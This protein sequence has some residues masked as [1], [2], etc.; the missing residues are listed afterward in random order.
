MKYLHIC[1]PL[2]VDITH[3]R[4][5]KAP[6]ALIHWTAALLLLQR[7]KKAR[8]SVSAQ[9][10][11]P[12]L[13]LSFFLL[14]SV[15]Y[16]FAFCSFNPSIHSISLCWTSDSLHFVSQSFSL[17]AAIVLTHSFLSVFPPQSQLSFEYL[18][19]STPSN[20]SNFPSASHPNFL[21]LCAPVPSSPTIIYLC[22][23][24]FHVQTFS[25]SLPKAR[26]SSCFIPWW[27]QE[28]TSKGV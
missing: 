14:C 16:L 3:N 19:S 2:A 5:S 18:S 22:Q 9:R 15:F 4:E 10:A 28:K 7:R 27:A 17:A 1:W 24:D 25:A 26:A 12:Y 20:R 8:C 23:Y 6:D 11:M 21:T 13:F